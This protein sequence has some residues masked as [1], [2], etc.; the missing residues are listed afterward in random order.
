[1]DCLCEPAFEQMYCTGQ[2]CS[3]H[4][5]VSSLQRV[6]DGVVTHEGGSTGDLYPWKWSAMLCVRSTYQTKL[7][8][9]LSLYS[10]IIGKDQNFF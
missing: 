3:V 1:M 5:D 8:T 4:N 9:L 7:N 6:S 10:D 2:T